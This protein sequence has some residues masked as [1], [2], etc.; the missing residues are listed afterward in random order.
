MSIEEVDFGSTVLCDWCSEDWTGRPESGGFLFGSKA[1][2][3]TCA[4]RMEAL[5]IEE[6]EAHYIR[7]RCP[8]DHS[9]AAW[10]L[11]LRAGNNKVR[12]LTGSDALEWMRGKQRGKQP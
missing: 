8:A 9:F 2:C 4:P 6:D 1:T 3:P 11:G 7:A 10:V 12:F 5:A